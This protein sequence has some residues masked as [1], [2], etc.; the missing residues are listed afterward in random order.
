MKI[1]EFFKPTLV[2]IILMI[3]IL[4]ILP[5]YKSPTI[6][7]AL[8]SLGTDSGG[9]HTEYIQLYEFPTSI[10]GSLKG[11]LL[12]PL[13][14]IS[15]IFSYIISCIIILEYNKLIIKIKK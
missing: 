13:F 4:L 8:Y 1:K 7:L 2:K 5:V 10:Y 11:L 3:I 9:C 15:L 6:C 14:Y 12:S